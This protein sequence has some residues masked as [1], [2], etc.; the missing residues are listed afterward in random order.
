MSKQLILTVGLP[1]SGKTTWAMAQGHPVVSMSSLYRLISPVY[2]VKP[3]AKVFVM[4]LFASG[5]NTVIVDDGNWLSKSRQ[6]WR[7]CDWETYI[8]RVSGPEHAESVLVHLDCTTTTPAEYTKKSRQ[9][10]NAL[11]AW[12][13]ITPD[14]LSY[15]LCS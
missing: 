14:E 15:H 13:E 2:L 3:T 5:Y 8:Y 1:H 10:Q 9:V 6:F 4:S 7:S 11:D 12:E